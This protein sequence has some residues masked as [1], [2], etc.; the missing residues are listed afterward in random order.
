MKD[1][2]HQYY[3]N[4]KLLQI[5]GFYY[6]FLF[7]SVRKASEYLK[8]SSPTIS[9][10]LQ[11]LQT[12]LKTALF[13]KNGNKLSLTEKGERFYKKI[14]ILVKN[15]DE[16]FENFA[17]EEKNKAR[18]KITIASQNMCSIYILPKVIT[19]LK[20]KFP[21][22]EITIYNCTPDEGI[23][24]VEDERVDICIGSYS[25]VPKWLSFECIRYLSAIYLIKSDHPLA[26][27]EKVTFS[28]IASYHLA[29]IDPENFTL[30]NFKA[31]LD[32]YNIRSVIELK[33]SD[34]IILKAYVKK[35][36]AGVC[37]SEICLTEQDNDLFSH[38][39][40]NYF[41]KIPY[42]YLMSKNKKCNPV[43]K[44][45]IKILSEKF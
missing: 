33:N 13:Y 7:G 23:K 28:D 36:L 27:K 18:K 2:Y 17:E 41:P 42:G 5:R 40:D 45:L 39:L 3:K 38:K 31:I 8:L 37:V 1:K 35:G 19:E 20:N 25:C 43:L 24:L 11:S 21:E 16:L 32:S 29:H 10:Q 34:W 15:F 26:K 44:S 14:E 9:I 6:T 4:N 12:A 22:S 30:P